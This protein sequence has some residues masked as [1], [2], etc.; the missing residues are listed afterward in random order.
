L[1]RGAGGLASSRPD[2]Q[3]GELS[4]YP[5]PIAQ[6]PAGGDAHDAPR[7]ALRRDLAVRTLQKRQK[8]DRR[9]FAPAKLTVPARHPGRAA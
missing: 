5:I 6:S 8:R 9:R 2:P 3:K 4:S 7:D 1:E